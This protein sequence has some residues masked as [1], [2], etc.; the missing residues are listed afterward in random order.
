VFGG[1]QKDLSSLNIFDKTLVNI[2]V[3]WWLSKE[4]L[5]HIIDTV[6]KY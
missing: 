5:N 4:D 1:I 2:P 3:G 6:N